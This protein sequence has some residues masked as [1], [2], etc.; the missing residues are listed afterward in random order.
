MMQ[1]LGLAM[2]KIDLRVE[3]DAW[4]ALENLEQLCRSAFEAAAKLKN[5]GGEV[6]LLLTD[7]AQMQVLN[8]DWRGKPKPTDVLSFP[9]DPMDAPFLGDIAVGVGVAT[10]D[11]Q[12]Q[13][14]PL[15]AH[16]QHLLIH[17]LLH[18][19][20]HDHEDDTEAVEMEELE[21]QALASLGVPDPYRSRS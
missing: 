17:G 12:A 8:T 9:A 2:I 21:R 19:A 15:T 13:S 4:D 5:I 10:R 18:L 20:G 11:A 14:K 1:T 7:D 3:S 16:L 6:S